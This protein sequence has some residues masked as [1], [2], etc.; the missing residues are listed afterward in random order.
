MHELDMV[1]RRAA[2]W[3]LGEYSPHAS[4]SDML[5]RLRWQTLEQRRSVARLCLFYKIINRLVSVPFLEHIV[6]PMRTTRTNHTLSFRSI[7]TSKDYYKYS[8]FPLAIVQWSAL[9][10]VAV[11]SPTLNSFK[12]AITAL[13][14]P[15]P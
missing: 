7:H 2:R 5:T 11:M 15:K 1:Q 12:T 4:V 8:F 14:H 13:Q 6:P 9:P 3:C 10:A